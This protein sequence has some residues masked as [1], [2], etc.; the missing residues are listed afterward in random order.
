MRTARRYL[1]REIYRSTAVVLLA[2][3]G[4]FMF[5]T[6]VD[7]LD[8]VSAKFPLTALF[9]LQ[10]LSVPTRLYDLLPI[11]LLIGAILALA[12]LAQRNELVILR[13]SGV[14]GMG[15]LKMLWII[16]IPIVLGATV[17]S[18]IITPIAEIKSSEANLLMRG[19]VEGGRL[20][21]GYWFKEPMQGGG[22]RIINI[23]RLLASGNAADLRIYEF[24][25]G[26]ALSLTSTA[27]SARFA[28]GQLIMQNVLE[29]RIAPETKDVLAD[30][31]VSDKP[32]V[33][34][35]KFANRKVETS[36][37]AERLVARILTPE[38]MTLRAL[39]DY[40]QYLER[41]QLQSD[42]QVVAVWRKLAYPFTLVVMLTIAAPIGFM[43]TRRGGVGAKVF[44]GI[45][46]GTGF[47]MINQ[48]ALNVGL[49]YKWPPVVTALLPNIGA[50]VLALT[51]IMAME[52]RNAI[53]NKTFGV[54]LGRRSTA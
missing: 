17:L 8:S 46:L 41:N 43:Q 45:L 20:A 25:D 26:T 53:I 2:L 48:L 54:W 29:T 51:A 11:G 3:L 1:A 31:K 38:R 39:N 14:S 36:L 24:P 5:F 12:G 23:G 18:E 44:L 13:V 35:E 30:A 33:V 27:E 21:S 28:D 16:S 22:T 52:H 40:I 7:E 50:T 32:V 37:T 49:L 4:L 34:K 19:R 47:F 10:A 9:Y 42:R 6:L 15:L